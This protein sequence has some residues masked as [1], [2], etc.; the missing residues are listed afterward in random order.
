MMCEMM[1]GMGTMGMMGMMM[2]GPILLA[3][4]IAVYFVVRTLG[5]KNTNVDIPMMILKERF[6]KGEIT[7]ADFNEK[8][9][10]LNKG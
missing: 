3:A 9:N 1:G 4:L 7:E 10:V 5:K 2:L 8:R 6:A